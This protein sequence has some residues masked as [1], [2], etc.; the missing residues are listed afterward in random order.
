MEGIDGESDE[1][2]KHKLQESGV[3]R[4]QLEDEPEMLSE[5]REP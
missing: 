5:G 4:R 3:H 1:E 2:T